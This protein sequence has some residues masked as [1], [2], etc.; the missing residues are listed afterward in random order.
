MVRFTNTNGFVS[1]TLTNSK[2]HRAELSFEYQL[3][4]TL[5]QLCGLW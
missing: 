2:K 1:Q 5:K 4:T 3:T